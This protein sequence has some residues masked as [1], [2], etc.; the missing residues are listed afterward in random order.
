MQVFTDG[1]LPKLLLRGGPRRSLLLVGFAGKEK[2]ENRVFRLSLAAGGCLRLQR[3]PLSLVAAGR[4]C[5]AARWSGEEEEKSE[6]EARRR[7]GG[8]EPRVERRHLWRSPRKLERRGWRLNFGERGREWRLG[9]GG[10]EEE[11]ELKF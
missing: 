7:S 3:C 4:S 1:A 2:R 11:N 6:V 5:V 8:W 10:R 9:E